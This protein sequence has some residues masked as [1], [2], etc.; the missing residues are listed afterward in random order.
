MQEEFLAKMARF[1]FSCYESIL[2]LSKSIKSLE[3]KEVDKYTS[4]N[5]C[6]SDKYQK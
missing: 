2:L 6:Y 3:F 1:F 5:L 4:G